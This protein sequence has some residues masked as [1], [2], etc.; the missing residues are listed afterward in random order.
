MEEVLELLFK[1]VRTELVIRG[2][3]ANQLYNPDVNLEFTDVDIWVK[4]GEA[5]REIFD[6]LKVSFPTAREGQ[7]LYENNKLERK[8][9][10]FTFKEKS[11]SMDFLIAAKLYQRTTES[12]FRNPILLPSKEDLLADIILANSIEPIRIDF[13]EKSEKRNKYYS[14]IDLLSCKVSKID[15]YESL[16]YQL[17]V[18]NYFYSATVSMID[19][20]FEFYSSYIIWIRDSQVSK[21]ENVFKLFSELSSIHLNNEK[22][23]IVEFYDSS[24]AYGCLSNFHD[25]EVKIDGCVWRT[26]EHYYQAEKFL[27]EKIKRSVRNAPNAKEAAKL[28]R[29]EKDL[30]RSDWD[31]VKVVKMYNVVKSKIVQTSLVYVTLLSTGHKSIVENS[32]M[33]EFWGIGKS[34]KGENVLGRIYMSIRNEIF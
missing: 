26:A 30:I 2:S 12:K 11:Y 23:K 19:M 24:E 29:N 34:G 1:E 14:L 17:E 10:E 18:Q 25:T 22:D 4:S 28:G 8:K 31:F 33:D 20:I 16:C 3:L 27:N 13:K 32:P 7:Y 15:L 21:S 5:F 9:V 6:L